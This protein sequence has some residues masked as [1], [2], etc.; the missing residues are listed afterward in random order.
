MPTLVLIACCLEWA[1]R[2]GWSIKVQGKGEGRAA[3]EG[4]GDGRTRSQGKRRWGRVWRDARTAAAAG[5]ARAVRRT[6]CRCDSN[7]QRAES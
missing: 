4:T 6:G 7:T 3:G 2:N 1:I 5:K